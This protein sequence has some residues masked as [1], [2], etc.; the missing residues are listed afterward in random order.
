MPWPASP[1]TC[2]STLLESCSTR[3]SRPGACPL[4]A[5]GSISPGYRSRTAAGAARPWTCGSC[6]IH[7][8]CGCVVRTAAC[9]THPLTPPAVPPGGRHARCRPRLGGNRRL[10]PA[11]WLKRNASKRR[12][13]VP[14]QRRRYGRSVP[15]G[16]PSVPSWTASAPCSNGTTRCSGLSTQ[17]R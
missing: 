1:S 5:P 2:C 10:P 12:S 11:S 14:R 7:H 9:S 6:P 16:R 13:P 17:F 15:N 8:S 4:P 3:P